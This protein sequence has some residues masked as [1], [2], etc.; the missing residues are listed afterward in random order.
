MFHRWLLKR[1]IAALAILGLSAACSPDSSSSIVAPPSSIRSAKSIV[2]PA[3]QAAA[4]D[5]V[6]S[7]N[8]QN[9]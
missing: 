8:E 3:D 6:M 5:A 9:N 7:G 4:L 2:P 1:Q